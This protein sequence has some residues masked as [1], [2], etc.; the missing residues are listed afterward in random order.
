MA[1]SI[2]SY[3][4]INQTLAP[5]SYAAGGVT[6]EVLD[7]SGAS[8]ALHIINLGTMEH[9]VATTVTA[10]IWES[11]TSGGTYSLISGTLTTMATTGTGEAYA[12]DVP[13]NKDKVYQKCISTA[14]DGWCVFATVGLAYAGSGSFP[15]TSE[16]TVTV[17]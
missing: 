11:A 2:T 3:V 1:E 7:C 6:E 16:N 8:R 4:D 17:V 12:I 13:V 14:N 9:N 10:S 5:L 15:K